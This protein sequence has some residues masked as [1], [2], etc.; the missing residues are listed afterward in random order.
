MNT[1]KFDKPMWRYYN[2]SSFE[3]GARFMKYYVVIRYDMA[4]LAPYT[5]TR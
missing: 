4:C 3:K 2:K 5:L 1:G